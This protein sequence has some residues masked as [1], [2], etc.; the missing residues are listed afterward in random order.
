[1]NHFHPPTISA[2]KQK[3]FELLLKKKGLVAPQAQ[4]TIPKRPDASAVPLSAPQKRIWSLHQ[5]APDSP[6]YNMTF[7]QQ[8]TGPL[9]V[10]ALEASLNEIVRRH[11]VLRTTFP[12]IN[13]QAV[14]VMAPTLTL[15]LPVAKLALFPDSEREAEAR[16]LTTEIVQQPFDLAT[17][18]LVRASLLRLD[19]QE[20]ILLIVFHQIVFDGSSSG[21]FIKEMSALYEAF[22]AGK[23]SPLPKL[24]L[25]YADFAH[26]QQ[27]QLQNEG[28]HTQLTYWKG[29]LGLISSMPL[30]T[31]RP[32]PAIE[33]GRGSLQSFMLPKSLVSALKGLSQ[34]EGSTLFMTLLAG[35]KSLLYG[36]SGQEDLL[37]FTS[38][39]G[40]NQ[41][42]LKPLIGLFAKQLPLRSDLTGDPSFRDLLGRVR[43]MTQDAFAKQD[44]P[45]EKLVELIQLERTNSHSSL[46]QV[47][48]VFLH[49]PRPSLE[50]S[51]LSLRPWHIGNQMAKF[52]LRLFIMAHED[53][54]TGWLEYKRDLFD[55]STISEMLAYFQSLLEQI[56]ANPNERLSRLLPPTQSLKQMVAQSE[57]EHI[58]RTHV[59]PRNALELQLLQIWEQV[60]G[61]HPISVQ[62]NFF[63]LGGHS[64]LALRL[65]EQIEKITG[66]KLPLSILLQAPTIEQLA[67]MLRQEDWSP[68]WSSLV[69]VQPSGSNPPLFLVPPAAC[70]ALRFATLSHYLGVEQPVYGF[71]PQGLDGT[72][73][74][75]ERVEEMAAHYIKEMCQLQPDAP[76]LLG[77]M[78]FGGYVALEMAQ[79]LQ[80]QGKPVAL[81]VLLDPGTPRNGPSWSYPKSK[82]SFIVYRVRRLI[83][84]SSDSSLP[85]R[86]INFIKEKFKRRWNYLTPQRR[87]YQYLL[88]VHVDAQMMYIAK[89]Y[90]GRVALFQSDQ[91]DQDNRYKSRWAA[92]AVGGLDYY[93]IPGTTH[94]SLLLSE[95]N[96]QLLAEQVNNCLSK[97]ESDVL[98]NNH[99]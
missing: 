27:Q 67:D 96:I 45:F 55:A 33:T 71:E 82:R 48:F 23:S 37:V 17:G 5:F 50:L 26:W 98:G 79:Q 40:R 30:P 44:V 19:S 42:E 52:D 85:W 70:T 39:E 1:M 20:H 65:F 38:A 59:A 10:E 93:M 2:E 61:L 35:L 49:E 12:E 58:E 47:M 94:Q 18:P 11:E 25:Q 15:S 60:F 54:L 87:H 63:A 92:L 43:K 22:W 7:A 13:G 81:L 24:P 90:S 86:L 89:R 69:A 53:E 74:P 62:D 14:A 29:Q 97:L 88:D 34:Q 36:I 80:R 75:H 91:Y 64:L 16:R 21:L 95:S 31:A 73:P 77:G 9:D 68:S 46:F 6:A 51:G 32:R 99:S 56:V 41:P 4:C 57:P 3:L 84:H 76:Y 28:L 72:T 78:C 83:S 66:Q 8:L